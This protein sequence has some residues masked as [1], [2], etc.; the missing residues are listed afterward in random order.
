MRKYNEAAA[1]GWP[2]T[3]GYL[4]VMAFG[5]CHPPPAV[6]QIVTDDNFAFVEIGVLNT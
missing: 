4:R 6:V 2:A 5:S 3:A 1:A